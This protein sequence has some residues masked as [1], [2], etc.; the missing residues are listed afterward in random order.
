[1]FKYIQKI[2]EKYISNMLKNVRM[3]FFDVRQDD[4]KKR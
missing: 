3:I 4:S 2:L 1:M